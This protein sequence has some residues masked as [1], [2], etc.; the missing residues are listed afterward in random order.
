M[1]FAAKHAGILAVNIMNGHKFSGFMQ[2]KMVV[3]LVHVYDWANIVPSEA[4]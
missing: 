1:L 4:S 2:G 3:T